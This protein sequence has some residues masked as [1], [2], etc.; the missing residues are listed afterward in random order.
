MPNSETSKTVTISFSYGKGVRIFAF[1]FGLL[2]LF[3]VIPHWVSF[4]NSSP[5][6]N[7]FIGIFKP[8]NGALAVV[9]SRMLELLI[10]KSLL[11][12]LMIMIAF[13][14]HFLPKSI[15]RKIN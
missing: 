2:L 7:A 5:F 15:V 13:P 8:F 4:L 12:C 1:V 6:S 3:S 11:A 14:N 10:L 9:A